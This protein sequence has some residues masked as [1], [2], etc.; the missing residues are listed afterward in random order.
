MI[1][2][3]YPV[4][5]TA[6]SVQGVAIVRALLDHGAYVDYKTQEGFDMISYALDAQYDGPQLLRLLL[7]HPGNVAHRAEKGE[8]S[9][10]DRRNP[11]TGRTPL[12]S[13]AGWGVPEEVDLLIGAG[14]K[15]DLADAVGQTALMDAAMQGRI[16][17]VACLL[18]H[19]ANVGLKDIRGHTALFMAHTNRADHAQTEY[20]QELTK[21]VWPDIVKM[22]EQARY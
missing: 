4:K 6:H 14:A 5:D 9:L 8:V 10:L 12:R 3:W 20:T 17:N 19:H 18:K 2:L 13:A 7:Q 15:V 21:D 16:E 22:L 1:K 11:F